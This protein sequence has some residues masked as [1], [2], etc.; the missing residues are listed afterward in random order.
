MFAVAPTDINWFSQLRQEGIHGELANFW[1]PTPWNITKLSLGDKLCFMLKSPIR[2]IGGYGHFYSYQN[3]K[4]SLA[5]EKF[6][7]DNGV[8][9]L[10]Q[11]IKRTNNYVSKNTDNTITSNPE[12]GCILLDKLEFFS[13]DEFKEDKELNFSFPAQVVKIKYFNQDLNFTELNAYK[14]ETKF[15]LVSDRNISRTTSKKKLRTG[16][17]KFRKNVLRAYKNK[18][19]IS[20]SN[21]RE[22]LEGAHIQT[23][24]NEKSNHIQNG[25]CLRSD[26][27]K[28]F[29]NGLITIDDQ[30]RIKISKILKTSGYEKYNDKQINLPEN[31]E[32][33]PS[34]EALKYHHTYI[35]RG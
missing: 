26:F 19:A 12:I 2:K 21:V 27:H 9:N 15:E 16:Q 10:S 4:A 7:R 33:Q 22:V 8:E 35:F 28:L 20:M 5:W 32:S 11:L 18:C 23:Y 30:F 31:E 34:K 29:D 17:A 13:D 6:G 24:F 3:M 1:T 25:I 14:S